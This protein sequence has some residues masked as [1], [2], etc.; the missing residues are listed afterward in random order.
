ML[1]ERVR[2]GSDDWWTVRV[3]WPH[4]CG[5]QSAVLLRSQQHLPHRLPS[6]Q[7][8]VGFASVGECV[9]RPDA[10]LELGARYPGEDLARAPEQLLARHHVV[11]QRW[12]RQ[13]QRAF[14]IQDLRIDRHD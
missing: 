13:I 9:L 7:R 3:T 4:D 5:L 14:L 11:V 10:E 2:L 12:P 1:R 8:T 6:L